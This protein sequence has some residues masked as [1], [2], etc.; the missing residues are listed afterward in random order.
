MGKVECHAMSEENNEQETRVD[1]N[2]EPNTQKETRKKARGKRGEV[3]KKGKKNVK[4][5]AREKKRNF[6]RSEGVVRLSGSIPWGFYEP[7]MWEFFS[8][9]GEVKRLKLLRSRRTGRSK[10]TAYLDFGDSVVAQIVADTMDKYVT[11]GETFYCNVVPPEELRYHM[12]S[13]WKFKMKDQRPA[14]RRQSRA[15]MFRRRG[16]KV[17]GVRVPVPTKYQIYKNRCADYKMAQKLKMA[18]VEYDMTGLVNTG[19]NDD[20]IKEDDVIEMDQHCPSLHVMSEFLRGRTFDGK[21]KKKLRHA[22]A[23]EDPGKSG[24]DTIG[25]LIDESGNAV[26]SSVDDKAI[27]PDFPTAVD[28]PDLPTKIPKKKRKKLAAEVENKESNAQE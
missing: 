3:K 5:K 1:V 13:H 26:G 8:Q 10:G 19:V 2:A 25:P 12:L 6:Y 7:Q 27:L 9:F 22:K 15:D 28:Q 14:R 23:V 24:K 16:V 17:E 21:K 11:L 18:D 4:L 20:V